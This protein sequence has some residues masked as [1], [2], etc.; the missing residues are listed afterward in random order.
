MR[1][2]DESQLMAIQELM[3]DMSP[4]EREKFMQQ[5]NQQAASDR[6]DSDIFYRQNDLALMRDNEIRERLVAE[7]MA[8]RQGYGGE[9]D[10]AQFEE[11][12]MLQMQKQ[13]HQEGKDNYD[14]HQAELMR[15]MMSNMS[16]DD[17][18]QQMMMMQKNE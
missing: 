13:M 10:P 14:E 2:M 8:G 9:E 4:G 6:L 16:M 15:N 12:M 3:Q 1:S 11:M 18:Q 5:M 7:A 17:M